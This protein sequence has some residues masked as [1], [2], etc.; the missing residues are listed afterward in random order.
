M[1]EPPLP[2]FNASAGTLSDNP[3][4]TAVAV[5]LGVVTLYFGQDIFIPFALAILLAFVLAPI[6]NWLR[7][8]RLPRVPAVL[9][10]VGFACLVIGAVSLVV[11]AQLVQLAENVPRYQTNIRDK[12]HTFLPVDGRGGIIGRLTGTFREI[13]EDIAETEETVTGQPGEPPS[14][15]SRPVPVIIESTETAPLDLLQTVALPLIEPLITG[16]IAIVFLVFVLLERDELR[17]RFIKLVGKGDL[18]KSTEALNE[19]ASRVSR[20]LLM[21]L[22]VNITYG[23]PIGIGL[24]FIGVPNAVLWGLL[25]AVLRFIP[26]LGPVLGALFPLALAFA[27]DPG[28]SML[29]WTGALFLVVE[30]ISNNFME[31]WLY[32]SST[33][34]SSLAVLLAAIFWTTLWGPVGLVLA[35]PL[36]VCLIVIGRYV[37]R[38]EFLGV[39]L[40]SDP[41]LEPEE[42]LYQRLLSGNTE[43]AID[44]AERYVAEHSLPEFYDDVAIPALCLAQSTRPQQPADLV[45]RRMVAQGMIELV[46]EIADFIEEDEPL[47]DEDASPVSPEARVLC[48]GGRTELDSAAATMVARRLGDHG[49]PALVLSPAAIGH[50]TLPQL[51]LDNIDAVCLSYLSQRPQVFA[52]QICRRLRRR[53][54]GLKIIACIWNAP[55]DAE[56]PAEMARKMSADAVASSVEAAS[57]WLIE[58]LAG[59]AALPS[60]A[61]SAGTRT[62]LHSAKGTIA[63]PVAAGA[64]ASAS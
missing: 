37:P 39:L 23:I 50:E 57:G 47:S 60:E 51:K 58:A 45:Q 9:V 20:Y 49:I 31:P 55:A 35:T 19:A 22:T 43:E 21:Q 7:R 34:L 62:G 40:G 28:W 1:P 4:L 11:G 5:M 53:S 18:R 63:A 2:Q 26:Y 8:W 27:V 29:L 52:R 13:A 30:L 38:L 41:V 17:D 36:T 48:I 42:R 10:A 54:P 33:G 25:A 16:G 59:D 64:G 15:E 32:G 44:I 12:L 6:V 46:D 24:Y 56:R 61:R 3:L 14:A